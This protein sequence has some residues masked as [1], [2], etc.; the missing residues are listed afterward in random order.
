LN[1]AHHRIHLFHVR[2]T[3]GTSLWRAFE[4]VEGFDSSHAPAW[5]VELPADTFTVTIL[6]DPVSRAVS[7]FRYL[8]WALENPDAWDREPALGQVLRE[9]TCIEGGWPYVRHQFETWRTESAI[10]ELGVRQFAR[11][12]LADGAGFDGFLT[13]VPPRR[14]LAQLYM[15]SRSFDPKEAAER[16]LALDSV[17]FTETFPEDLE[18][19]SAMLG[20]ELAEKHERRFGS[21]VELSAEQEAALRALLRPEYEMLERVRA[22]DP[23]HR[24]R[25]TS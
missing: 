17:C 3:A 19:L 21:P 14:L 2:K 24:H 20:V 1:P 6:R 11:R 8:A 13:R 12:L 4:G 16:I 10:R 18:R 5:R 9:A 23:Q 15:F 22:A 25:V 7:Y